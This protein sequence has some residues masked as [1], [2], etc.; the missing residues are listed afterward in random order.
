V[1]NCFWGKISH[2]LLISRRWARIWQ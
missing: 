2:F 1:T